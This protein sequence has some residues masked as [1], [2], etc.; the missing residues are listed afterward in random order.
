LRKVQRN[1]QSGESAANNGDIKFHG[2]LVVVDGCTI[3]DLAF[4][5]WAWSLA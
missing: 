3:G 4:G 1:G 5:R 2:K